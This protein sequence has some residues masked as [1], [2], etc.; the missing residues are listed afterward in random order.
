[1]VSRTG[2][3]SHHPNEAGQR[4]YRSSEGLQAHDICSNAHGLGLP[5]VMK[6]GWNV[7]SSRSQYP[8]HSFQS[9]QQTHCSRLGG[10]LLW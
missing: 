7:L 8:A 6:T 9:R 5:L 3:V 10:L 4:W 2:R 1:M